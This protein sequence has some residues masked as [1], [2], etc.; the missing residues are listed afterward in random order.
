MGTNEVIRATSLDDL[1][2]VVV[3]VPVARPDGRTVVVPMRALSEA[4]VFER[5]QEI[6]WPAPPA[7]DINKVNGALVTTYN[8]QDPVYVKALRAANRK[9][10]GLLLLD[11]LTFE[12]AGADDGEKVATLQAKLGQ[13]AWLQLVDAYNRLNTVTEDQIASMARSFRAD[14]ETGAAGGAAVAADAGAVAEPAAG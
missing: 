13:T 11:S 10:T 2:G 4:A 5:R 9:F 3:D 7:S 1:G 14:R 6:E 12:V 8:F